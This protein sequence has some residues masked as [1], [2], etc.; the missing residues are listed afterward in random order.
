M[1]I[2]APYSF[3]AA[4]L[5]KK[6]E[7]SAARHKKTTDFPLAVSEKNTIFVAEIVTTV[8]PKTKHS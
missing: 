2:C 5:S 6:S 3:L 7:L 1:R 4:K 8:K